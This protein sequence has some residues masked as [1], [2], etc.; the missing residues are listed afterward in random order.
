MAL[1][2]IEL[3]DT[4]LGNIIASVRSAADILIG[5]A[6]YNELNELAT[7]VGDSENWLEVTK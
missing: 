6:R 5:T 7:Y 4:Q 2:T 1:I 3:T